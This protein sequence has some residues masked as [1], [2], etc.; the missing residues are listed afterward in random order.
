MIECG[1]RLASYAG[2]EYP[3]A[4]ILLADGNTYNA[5]NQMTVGLRRYNNGRKLDIRRFSGYNSSQASADAIADHDPV[6]VPWIHLR[7]KWDTSNV[8]RGYWSPDG[9]SWLTINTLTYTMTPTH[10]GVFITSF[11]GGAGT[12]QPFVASFDY[13]RVVT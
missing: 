4:G 5:G 8:W 7:L 11:G 13:L 12:S 1:M 10:A 6:A 9:L 2:M 3:W